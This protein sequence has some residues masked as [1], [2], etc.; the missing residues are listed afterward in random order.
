MQQEQMQ[1]QL[2]VD[3][4]HLNLVSDVVYVSNS[5]LLKECLDCFSTF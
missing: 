3:L 5:M 1:H 4:Y 2:I